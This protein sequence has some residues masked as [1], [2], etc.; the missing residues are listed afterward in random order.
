MIDSL[1]MLW[2]SRDV[3][4]LWCEFTYGDLY[5]EIFNCKSAESF[6]TKTSYFNPWNNSLLIKILCWLLFHM[7]NNPIIF[8]V[9]LS[10]HLCGGMSTNI[11]NTENAHIVWTHAY[12][13][14]YN[15]KKHPSIHPWPYEQ[16]ASTSYCII[17]LT[18]TS[19]CNKNDIWGPYKYKVV[20][21]NIR[22][23]NI[24]W[25]KFDKMPKVQ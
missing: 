16:N 22:L 10:F 11:T 23:E 15:S 9:T 4:I 5:N 8:M 6:T 25:M 13:K 17:V 14:I 18:S 20:L 24:I 19:T 7:E 12:S 21:L 2:A 3:A 1:F